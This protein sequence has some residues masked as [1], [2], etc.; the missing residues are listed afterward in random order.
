VHVH[1]ELELDLDGT[2]FTALQVT[3][4]EGRERI[5]APYCFT[6]QAVLPAGEGTL[7]NADVLSAT[8]ILRFVERSNENVETTIRTVRGVVQSF[9]ESLEESAGAASYSTYTFVVAPRLASSA[10]SSRK[11]STSARATPRSCAPS[12]WPRR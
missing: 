1:I 8:A 2:P 12:W 11:T 3:S 9:E 6:V 7:A 4:V 10:A 5:G